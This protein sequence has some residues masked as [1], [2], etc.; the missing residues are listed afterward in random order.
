MVKGGLERQDCL[1]PSGSRDSQE[2]K[3]RL[4]RK[5]TREQR[6]LGRQGQ[7]VLQDLRA[8]KVFR[9]Q[10]EKQAWMAVKERRVPR[11]KKETGGLWDCLVLQDQSG[12]QAQLDQRAKGAARETQG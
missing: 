3:E 12:F 8:S 9:D 7:R 11:E 6:C 10:R 1:G 5:A 2:R 4:G